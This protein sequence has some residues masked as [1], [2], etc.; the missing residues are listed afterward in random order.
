MRWTEA[1]WAVA[2]GYKDYWQFMMTGPLGHLGRYSALSFDWLGR[3]AS[4]KA[5]R[6]PCVWFGFS[7]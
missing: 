2:L 3:I 4:T 1:G 7:E 6:G 5:C